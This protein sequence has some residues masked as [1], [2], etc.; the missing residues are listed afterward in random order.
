MPS[1]A[2]DG[3][4]WW[5]PRTAA[6]VLDPKIPATCRPLLGSPERLRNWNS[7]C[8]PYRVA[9]A[10]LLDRDD[11]RPPRLSHIALLRHRLRPI[12]GG[13]RQLAYRYVSGREE[14]ACKNPPG[15]A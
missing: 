6:S 14:G 8:P 3:M 9:L 1:T 2:T 5:K 11:H 12:R 10:A 7:S 13:W 4:S 15:S